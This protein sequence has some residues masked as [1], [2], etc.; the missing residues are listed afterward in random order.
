MIR[1]DAEYEAALAQ[2]Q[3]NKEA[4]QRHENELGAAGL[5]ASQV[6][7]AIG[8]IASFQGQLEEEVALYE[9]MRNGKFDVTNLRHLGHALIGLRIS[10]RIT[11][12][13][14]AAKLQVHESQV[15][16][17]ERSEYHG[18]S[19]ERAQSVIDAIGAH[20]NVNVAAPGARDAGVSRAESAQY[21]NKLGPDANAGCAA[22]ADLAL[23][24]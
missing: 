8:V 20:I 18:V 16:R 5:S 11:Q 15:S 14:L 17:W 7:A 1:T 9:Q 21:L 10:S 19:F 3:A 4:R 23:A 12:R 2:V 6:S 22:N 24:A 13:E